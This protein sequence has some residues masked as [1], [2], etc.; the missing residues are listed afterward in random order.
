MCLVGA[1]SDAETQHECV[2]DA[3]SD[4]ILSPAEEKE[5]Q[6]L[7]GR[8]TS[9][10]A[11]TRTVEEQQRGLF[12]RGFTRALLQGKWRVEPCGEDLRAVPADTETER[13]LT[14]L[15]QEARVVRDWHDS[16]FIEGTK[17]GTGLAVN[18]DDG[19]ISISLDF[20]TDDPEKIEEFRDASRM[21]LDLSDWVGQRKAEVVA[22]IDKQI[23]ALQAKRAGYLS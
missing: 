11:V 1:I 4:T 8:L 16:I 20:Y 18:F 21:N 2:S 12:T 6:L 13:R 3:P 19:A 22:G 15:A 14:S 5:W 9:L 7:E 23:A 10:R 17:H